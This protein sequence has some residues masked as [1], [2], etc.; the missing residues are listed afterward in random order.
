MANMYLCNFKHET[1]FVQIYNRV[2]L[3]QYLKISLETVKD[4]LKE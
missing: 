1:V 2:F 4:R 3:S